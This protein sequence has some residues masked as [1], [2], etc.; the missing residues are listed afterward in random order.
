ML[1]TKHAYER[2]KMG[3]IMLK[4]LNGKEIKDTANTIKERKWETEGQ[5]RHRNI[6]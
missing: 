4:S 3:Y 5:Q 2:T 6:F 1:K